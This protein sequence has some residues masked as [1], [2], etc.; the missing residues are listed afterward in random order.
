M[1]FTYFLVSYNIVKLLPFNLLHSWA[2]ATLRF[3][4]LSKSVVSG[5]LMDLQYFVK[6]VIHLLFVSYNIVKLHPFNS[7]HRWAI[8][9]LRFSLLSKSVVTWKILHLQYF[10]EICFPPTSYSLKVNLV[11]YIW[12]PFAGHNFCVIFSFPSTLKL[13]NTR[14][15]DTEPVHG[16]WLLVSIMQI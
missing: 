3:S 13:K 8:A 5:K 7:L 16:H 12:I 4:L 9:T 14:S 6:Y 10:V 2:I 1:L 15:T 11:L